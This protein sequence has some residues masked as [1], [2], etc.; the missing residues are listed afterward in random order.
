MAAKK[1]G[2]V[3]FYKLVVFGSDINQ[4]DWTGAL[5]ILVITSKSFTNS[6]L[7]IAFHFRNEIL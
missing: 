3:W 5:Y 1:Y 4:K 6:V 7:I 2:Q